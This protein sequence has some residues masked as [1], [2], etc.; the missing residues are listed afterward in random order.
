MVLP[1]KYVGGSTALRTAV[2]DSDSEAPFVGRQ[3]GLFT[4][5]CRVL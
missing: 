4:G 2:A 3:G 1:L 5:G